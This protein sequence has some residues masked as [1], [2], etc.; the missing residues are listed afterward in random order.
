MQL[1]V[2]SPGPLDQSPIPHEKG[3]NK[4]LTVKAWTIYRIIFI[5][6]KSTNIPEDQMC[7][8]VSPVFVMQV[9]SINSAELKSQTWPPSTKLVHT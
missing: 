6:L 2:K 5:S 7:K 4:M 8:E 9:P 1:S 3:R